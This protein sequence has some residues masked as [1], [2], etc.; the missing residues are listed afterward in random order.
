MKL[1]SA[2]L[3]A[4]LL[5]GSFGIAPA[6]AS[7]GDTYTV[8]EGDTLFSIAQKCG[9]SYIVLMDINYEISDPSLIRPGQV[10]RT[11]AEV[12]LDQYHQPVSGPAQPGGAQPG[13][14]YIVRKGDSLARI[15]YLYSTTLAAVYD[16]NPQLGGKPMIYPGQQIQLPTDA[17]QK[18]GWVGVS[19]LYPDPYSSIIVRV[20][21]FP[22][23]APIIYRLYAIPYDYETDEYEN[24]GIKAAGPQ[25]IVRDDPYS[26]YVNG[27]TDARGSA[28]ATIKLSYYAYYGDTW[29]VDVFTDG[30]G[31]QDALARSPEMVIGGVENE[32]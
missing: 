8:S 28:H 4:V 1:F 2:L 14:V 12:P 19:T 23:Y 18:K 9:I 27:T 6:H 22:P 26:V 3:I 17:R 13:G 21:D 16:A 10:I 24:P 15:A 20:V 11:T 25:D 31:E 32:Y 7:C 29:V 30:L 5:L